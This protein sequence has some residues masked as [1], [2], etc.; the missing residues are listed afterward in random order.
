MS[1][2][3]EII[4]VARH[5]N[6]VAGEP[7]WAVLFHWTAED[8]STDRMLGIVHEQLGFCSVIGLDRIASGGVKFGYNSWRG[9]HF[10]TKLRQEIGKYES[11]AEMN[12]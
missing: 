12:I 3:Y 5:R 8:G 2:G 1:E 6:G 7:F 9:D 10:E 4:E 11:L